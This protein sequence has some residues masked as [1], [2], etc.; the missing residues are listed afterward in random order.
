MAQTAP[1]PGPFC[2]EFGITTTM[3]LD[4]TAAISMPSVPVVKNGLVLELFAVLKSN[5]ST[6]ATFS[7][8]IEKLYSG[9]TKPNTWA[10][11][12]SN[13]SKY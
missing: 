11:Q 3:L 1:S 12:V 7:S 6:W 2:A 13:C 9:G 10:L 5:K 4:P 8:W